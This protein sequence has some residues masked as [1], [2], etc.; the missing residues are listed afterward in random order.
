[1]GWDTELGFLASPTPSADKETRNTTHP[2]LPGLSKCS[3][4]LL[5]PSQR[6]FAQVWC[7]R[8]VVGAP[9]LVCLCWFSISAGRISIT[10]Y[11][12]GGVSCRSDCKWQQRA[13]CHP[14]FP[15]QAG[16]EGAQLALTIANPAHVSAGRCRQT[17][18]W[19]DTRL[20]LATKKGRKLSGLGPG[21]V[22]AV[23]LLATSV[24]RKNNKIKNRR[25][26]QRVFFFVQLSCRE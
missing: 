10:S 17:L 11:L 14:P 1:M 9:A 12:G 16:A 25:K 26:E 7:C 18:G 20:A 21:A 24:I 19:Q 22:P 6:G 2:T 23:L 4:F 3:W 5:C 13:G 15:S 8:G